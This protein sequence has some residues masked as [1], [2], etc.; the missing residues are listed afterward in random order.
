MTGPGQEIALLTLQ[1]L[2]AGYMIVGAALVLGWG[3]TKGRSRQ[4]AAG[5]EFRLKPTCRM[6][7]V[8]VPTYLSFAWWVLHRQG[9]PMP[10]QLPAFFIGVPCLVLIGQRGT[11]T[12]TPT[13]VTQRFWLLPLPPKQIA[14][15]DVTMIQSRTHRGTFTQ[16][17]GNTRVKIVHS[18]G[19]SAEGEF[20]AEMEK[21]TGKRVVT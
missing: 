18:P 20:R 1:H 15:E 21:R 10:W 4:T 16:V 14:Y 19:H 5:V 12:L 3:L 7:M 6:F 8:F 11:I 2:F 13:A 17:R 9:Y